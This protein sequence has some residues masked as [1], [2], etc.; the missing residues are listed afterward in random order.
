M[1]RHTATLA[2]TVT[3]PTAENA[4]AWAETLYD[5][6]HAEYGG[7]MRLDIT[8]NPPT[9]PSSGDWKV[10]R[11][12]VTVH[13]AATQAE[14]QAVGTYAIRQETDPNAR[15]E[16]ICPACYGDDQ[17]CQDCSDGTQWYFAAS[18]VWTEADYAIQRAPAETGE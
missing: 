8:V 5:H 1:T 12:G 13:T 3:A 7:T 10:T 16:W 14:A 15:V 6:V 11:G 18:G 9:L 4:D 17:E 2:I